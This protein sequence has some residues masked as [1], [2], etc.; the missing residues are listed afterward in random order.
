MDHCTPLT[1]PAPW[2]ESPATAGGDVPLFDLP[3][4][5][6]RYEVRVTL[7]RDADGP[8]PGEDQRI[9]ELAVAALCAD[10]LIAA[11]AAEQA[12]LSMLL[13]VEDD[14]AA[15]AAG[16]AMVRAVGGTR[17]ASVSAERVQLPGD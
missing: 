14:A 8:A 3:R 10:G 9:A 6:R 15:L 16:V 13:D 2:V 11:W 17:G 5:P 1:A 7:N 12:V 4:P